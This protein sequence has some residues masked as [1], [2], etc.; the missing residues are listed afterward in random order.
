MA[1]YGEYESLEPKAGG[2]HADYQGNLDY[3]TAF[4]QK[5]EN[6]LLKGMRIYIADSGE[7]KKSLMIV[8]FS[9]PRDVPMG[10]Y[11]APIFLHQSKGLVHTQV[12][13][14]FNSY[15]QMAKGFW[16]RQPK[17]K[18]IEIFNDF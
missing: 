4:C 13:A 14:V 8:S 1:K 18:Q 3:C 16:D 10:N 17:M 15:Y 11:A 7:I 9:P 6:N 5:V 12:E 2:P